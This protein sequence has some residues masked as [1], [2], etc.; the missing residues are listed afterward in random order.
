MYKATCC[1]VDLK[2]NYSAIA[3]SH[4]K[5]IVLFHGHLKS[6]FIHR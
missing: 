6:L 3:Q 4:E 5:V 2:V 1:R